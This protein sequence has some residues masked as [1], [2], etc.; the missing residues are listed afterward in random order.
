M[1]TTYEA[2]IA[3][4]EEALESLLDEL[5]EQGSDVEMED[6]DDEGRTSEE[7]R[8]RIKEEFTVTLTRLVEVIRDANAAN[9]EDLSSIVAK[10]DGLLNNAAHWANGSEEEEGPYESGCIPSFAHISDEGIIKDNSNEKK[11]CT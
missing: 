3:V 7:N 9:Y 10:V 5:T 11:F 1:S 4:L 2:R 6:E 8:T